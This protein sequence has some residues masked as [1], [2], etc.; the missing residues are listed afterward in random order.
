MLLARTLTALV[1]IPLAI[2]AIFYLPPLFFVGVC[3]AIVSL[4]IWE[5]ASFFWPHNYLMHNIFLAV[6]LVLIFVS[7]FFSPF[8][9]LAIGGLWWLAVPYL[10]VKYMHNGA[11]S[12]RSWQSKFV[13][14]VLTFIP[15]FTGLVTLRL[16]F[17]PLYLLFVLAIIWAAD[18]GA[19]FS[20]RFFGK[21]LLAE[22]ISP[23][24]TVEGVLGGLVAAI[25]VAIIAGLV[26]GFT[27]WVW[28]MWLLLVTVVVLWSIIGDL[29]E[30]MLKRVAQVKDSGNILPGH[31]G[32]YDR[33]DSITAAVPIFALG[34]LLLRL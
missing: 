5:M 13:V 11:F 16:D 19:Y 14:G 4:A 12:I 25:V 2:G 30:S 33:I 1:L 9:T 6:V 29:F 28:V 21:H 20:G 15:C 10:L 18:I 22:R 23:K 24:K 34:L 8:F 3:A 31:G 32:V 7:E 27:G 26:L 17:G